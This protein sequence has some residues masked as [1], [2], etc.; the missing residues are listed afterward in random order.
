MY[1]KNEFDEYASHK[2]KKMLRLIAYPDFILNERKL[3]EFYKGLELNEYDSYGEVLE[4]VA[5]WNI[6]AVFER[7][8]KPL[9][10]TDYNF[11]S[12][13]VNAYYDTLNSIS[14]PQNEQLH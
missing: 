11:N 2:T 4:K 9:D 14:K 7:L 12:A 13:A 3:D 1:V 10:R 8:T 5:V 6:K